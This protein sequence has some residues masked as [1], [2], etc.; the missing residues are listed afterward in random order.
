MS[1]ARRAVFWL[2]V[3]LLASSPAVL[4]EVVLRGTGVV[5]SADPYLYLG[6]V[7]SFF[8]ETT[9]DGKRHYKVISREVYRERNVTFSAEK[10]PGT[11]RIFC[12]GSSASAGWPHP[13]TEIYS[14][15]LQEAL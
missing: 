11:V 13:P 14:A 1:R 6:R 7:P 5:L 2:I 4:A 3:L 10:A 8:A 15:Y 12:I 9:I